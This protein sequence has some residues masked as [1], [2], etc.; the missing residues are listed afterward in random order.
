MRKLTGTSSTEKNWID[1]DVS[2][3][4]LDVTEFKIKKMREMQDDFSR[5]NAVLEEKLIRSERLA[6]VGQM[7]AGYA[8]ELNNSLTTMLGYTELVHNVTEQK[9]S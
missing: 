6:L 4:L 9:L 2:E 3:D 8:H 1:N 5:E 7:A